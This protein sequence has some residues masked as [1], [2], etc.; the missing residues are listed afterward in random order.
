[1]GLSSRDRKRANT[2]FYFMLAANACLYLEAGAVPAVLLQIGLA[3]SM[4]SGQQGLLGGIVY[5]AL[6]IG[7]PFAGYLLRRYSHKRVLSLAVTANCILT[8]LW[9][10]TPVGHPYSSVM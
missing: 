6:S 9:A 4:N 7:G 5:L 2:L 8:T 1:M 10:C 3:F